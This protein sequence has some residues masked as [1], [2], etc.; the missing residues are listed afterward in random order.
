MGGSLMVSLLTLATLTSL[1][2]LHFRNVFNV[3]LDKVF[4]SFQC[5]DACFPVMQLW[6]CTWLETSSTCRKSVSSKFY[7]TVMVASRSDISTTLQAW[8]VRQLSVHVATMFAAPTLLLEVLAC[9]WVKGANQHGVWALS[10]LCCGSGKGNLWWLG[11][12]GSL[13]TNIALWWH[14]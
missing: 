14:S 11:L 1:P 7:G 8:R 3:F 10:I 13:W 6:A 5:M 2:S 9:T 12:H 4:W